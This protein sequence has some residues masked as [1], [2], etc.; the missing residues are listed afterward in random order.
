MLDTAL[1]C[2]YPGLVLGDSRHRCA[3]CGQGPVMAGDGFLMDRCM[4]CGSWRPSNFEGPSLRDILWGVKSAL[5]SIAAKVKTK[6]GKS[7]LDVTSLSE[8]VAAS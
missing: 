3:Y 2:S 5:K 7:R 1:Y 8:G 6:F 4:N